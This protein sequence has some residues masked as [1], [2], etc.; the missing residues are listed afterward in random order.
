MVRAS[1]C[2][3][4]LYWILCSIVPSKNSLMLSINIQH[5]QSFHKLLPLLL[6]LWVPSLS[7]QRFSSS[8]LKESV[9]F[10]H[11][12]SALASDG[13][14]LI[15]PSSFC[16]FQTII[17]LPVLKNPFSLVSIYLAAPPITSFLAFINLSV[18]K[19]HTSPFIK[20]CFS[21]DQNVNFWSVQTVTFCTWAT[22]EHWRA[23]VDCGY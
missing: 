7:P 18:S 5:P 22:E 23:N 16:H 11:I 15:F 14:A 2:W 20:D 6:G 1:S 19:H 17:C 8:F 10:F 12:S 21:I 4:L 13:S 9:Q 3:V